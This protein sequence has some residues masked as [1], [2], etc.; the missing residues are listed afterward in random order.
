MGGCILKKEGGPPVCGSLVGNL[1]KAQELRIVLM[2]GQIGG[3]WVLRVLECQESRIFYVFLYFYMFFFVFLCFFFHEI[4]AGWVPSEVSCQES[5]NP[6]IQ[7]W[8]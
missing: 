4:Q 8:S 1:Q 5:R 6:E 7:T 3:R 2:V